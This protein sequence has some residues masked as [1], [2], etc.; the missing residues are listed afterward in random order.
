MRSLAV[1]FAVAFAAAA[2]GC[3]AY[4]DP[5]LH[6]AYDLDVRPILMAHCVRCHGAGGMLNVPTEPTGP[7]AP[8]L[9]SL[10]QLL[11]AFPNAPYL[12]RFENNGNSLGAGATFATISSTAHLA[13][14]AVEAMPPL[15][16]P[17][18]NAWELGVIAN[19]AK[20]ANSPVCSNSPNPDLTICPLG[21]GTYAS[22]QQ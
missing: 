11:P 7:N 4:P 20:D 13:S 19:W 15:P 6:P 14:D 3:D 2:A 8:T 18:L 12:D 9:P 22:Q 5:P 16:A 21:P 1:L 10:T 17:R